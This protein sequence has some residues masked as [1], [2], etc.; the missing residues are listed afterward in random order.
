M[1]D[2]TVND[3]SFRYAD[4]DQLILQDV[5]MRVREGDFVCLLGQSGCGK[6]TFLRLMAGLEAPSSGSICVDGQPIDGT[7]LERSVVFQDYGLFPWMSAGENIVLALRQ[8][9]PEKSKA[10]CRDIA[11][12]ALREVGLKDEVFGK[13]P[14]SLSGGMRQRCA[15]ARSFSM[16]P[17]ILLMDEPFGALDAV[18][19]ARLQDMVLDLWS[20]EERKKTVFFVTHD[21]EEA[22]FLA[23]RIVVFGQS[24]SQVIFEK[25]IPLERKPSRK[26]MYESRFIMDLRN[27]LVGYINQDV[28]SHVED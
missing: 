14:K 22:L 20:H 15:I 23:T 1:N 2:I 10:E 18:T 5:N 27:E 12:R 17:P 3:L 6:S 7:S 4:S 11:R 8:R 19:R 26:E 9:F 16:N 24:P 28:L 25:E 13:Y 21:V